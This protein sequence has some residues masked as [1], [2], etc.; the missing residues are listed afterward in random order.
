MLI[1]IVHFLITL[2]LVLAVDDV[3]ECFTNPCEHEILLNSRSHDML[4]KR[5]KI[6]NYSHE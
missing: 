4:V 6:W 5:L 1:N 3:V 2:F